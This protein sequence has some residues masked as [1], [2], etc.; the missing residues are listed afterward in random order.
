MILNNSGID[1][2]RMLLL[3]FFFLVYWEIQPNSCAT[4]NTWF[5][6]WLQSGHIKI[7]KKTI[8]DVE[9][10][11]LLGLITINNISNPFFTWKIIIFISVIDYY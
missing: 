5:M 3:M 11:N 7:V 4:D 9:E 10:D 6:T 2:S 1:H 8:C